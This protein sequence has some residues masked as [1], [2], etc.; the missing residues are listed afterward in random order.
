VV[1]FILQPFFRMMLFA[2]HYAY[3]PETFGLTHFGAINGL[4]G[5][6][7]A[8]VGLLA[9]PLMTFTL[10]KQNSDWT[11]ALLMLMSGVAAGSGASL[12]LHRY[13]LRSMIT[14][15]PVVIMAVRADDHGVVSH[16]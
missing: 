7:G 13:P 14:P 2:F 10:F 16:A 4:T 1:A 15:R 6:I 5:L 12:L 9:Y 8:I 3:L 11:V